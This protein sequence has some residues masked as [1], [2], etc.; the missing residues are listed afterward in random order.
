MYRV[1]PC[2]GVSSTRDS[3]PTLFQQEPFVMTKAQQSNKESKKQPN[4]NLKE[5]RAKRKAK[6]DGKDAI[7]GFHA[8]IT[9]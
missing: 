1:L 5:K 3:I 4:L 7:P 8:Q 2:R 9:R 6:K